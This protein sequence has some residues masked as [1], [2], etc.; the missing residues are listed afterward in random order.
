[1]P[2]QR[3][4]LELP[5][6]WQAWPAERKL[7]LRDRLRL[8]NFQ[9]RYRYDPAGFVV[10]C[11]DWDLVGRERPAP[12]QLEILG[13]LVERKRVAIRGPHGLGKT[14][15][16]SAA[17]H[18]FALTR[19]GVDDW[20]IPTT[21]SKWRQLLEY[22]WPEIRKWP[23]YFRWDLIGRA[24]Y[25]ER[26]ELQNLALRLE[27][28]SAFAVASDDPAGIEGAHADQV[29]YLYDEAKTI[30]D[31]TFDA[32]EGAFSGAGPDTGREAYGFA[33]STP[34]P[35]QGRFYQIHK[36]AKGYQNWH[37]R[38]VTLD[39]A[40]AAGRIS[41]M[42]VA[43]RRAAWGDSSPVFQNRVLGEF[44][45]DLQESVI[46]LGWV[47]QAIERW[48]ELALTTPQRE[49]VIPEEARGEFT[50][51]G[52]DVGD[53]GPDA[54]VMALRY[55]LLL[56]E[57][58]RPDV[59]DTM[60]TTGRIVGL[61]RKIGHGFAV[62]DVIGVG[63]GPVARLREQKVKV[64]AFNASHSSDRT[65]ATGELEFASRRAEAWW[66]L[67]EMLDPKSNPMV[68][69]PND[70]DMIGD[71]TAPKWKT[72]SSGKV[73]VESKDDIRK[74]LGRSTDTGDAVVMAFNGRIP[75]PAKVASARDRV[76][77]RA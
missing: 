10:D 5:E 7:A 46:P 17:L 75:I 76:L 35:P 56:A 21:A 55:G 8:A 51:V 49:L 63:T 61:L 25:D 30:P 65:D 34:G 24:P 29:M 27:T 23:R 33:L 3:R 36:R 48:E 20:K 1:M 38:H 53:S 72:T 50:C 31:D 67:R 39:E 32:T 60:D 13:S 40:V 43:E 62:V 12:Y 70:D 16:A 26:L 15:I 54:T 59:V 68:A 73:L 28:G 18:W 42:W 64:D 37:A 6:G 9:T 4:L 57:I 22:L 52:V 19:D 71:L 58:R 41:T 77:P 74:R 69:L 11:I 44:A 2:P 47:E 45:E 14:M 66:G